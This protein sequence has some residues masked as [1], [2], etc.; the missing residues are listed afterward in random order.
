MQVRAA[1]N[2]IGP[3]DNLSVCC[4]YW[5]SYTNGI[6]KCDLQVVVTYL[7]IGNL[8]LKK[9]IYI[10]QMVFKYLIY[11]VFIYIQVFNAIINNITFALNTLMSAGLERSMLLSEPICSTYGFRQQASKPGCRVRRRISSVGVTFS[12]KVCIQ[13]P[14]APTFLCCDHGLAFTTQTLNETKMCLSLPSLVMR[15][16]YIT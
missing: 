12:S 1:Q 16:L 13:L 9:Y 15:N 2:T 11:Y 10:I 6:K 3:A 7:N 8:E 5:L 14:A 4:Q